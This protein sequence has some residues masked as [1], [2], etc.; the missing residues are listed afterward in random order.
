[1]YGLFG[2]LYL[3]LFQNW[4]ILRTPWRDFIGLTVNVIVA[5]AIGLLPYIDNYA[6]VGGFVSGILAGL[7]FMPTITFGKWDGRRK[8]ILMIGAFPL[9]CLLWTLGFIGFY[10]QRDF[11]CNWCRYLDCIPPDSAWCAAE[12]P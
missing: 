11:S 7:T 2:V 4:P 9:L 8:R 12:Q 3:D 5:L 1:M 6:H 10:S